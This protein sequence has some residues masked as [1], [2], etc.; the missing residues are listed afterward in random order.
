MEERELLGSVYCPPAARRPWRLDDLLA[1]ARVRYYGLG[2][3]ALTDALR[4]AGFPRG[5][6][7]LLPAFVCA[8]AAAAVTSAGCEPV[9]L[10]V[11][12][13]LSPAQC[14]TGWPDVSA[15][16]AIDYFGFPQDLAPFKRYAARRNALL[17]ED[18]AH[19]LFSRTPDGTWLGL[20]GDAGVFSL[21]KTIPI[22]NGAALAIP[23]GSPLTPP[24][25]GAFQQGIPARY[26][27]KQG[28]RSL[29][30]VTGTGPVRAL[31][32][33]LRGAKREG[34]GAP[35]DAL[36]APALLAAPVSIADP[37]LEVQRRRELYAWSDARLKPIGA[38]PVFPQ[39][40]QGVSPY[41]YAFRAPEASLPRIERALDQA[42]L[43]LFPW[44]ELPAEVE[45]GAPGHYRDVR[46]VRFLW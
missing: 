8:E 34:S 16:I 46:C 18:N 33:L 29:A 30:R 21:R 24:P 2:R 43:D 12:P 20:R 44:P 39:L 32:K 11:A 25:P 13:S 1:P 28:L 26:R 15:M 19:G 23:E 40:P 36:V 10:P 41:T 31:H 9:Y 42:G 45:R 5:S 17:I 14:E 6:K 37:E 22:A 27:V 35:D 4:A 7:V 38:V 3:A